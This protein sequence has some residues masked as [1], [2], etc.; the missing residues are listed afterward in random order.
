MPQHRFALGIL[1]VKRWGGAH[2]IR[3]Q[4]IV[5]VNR[6]V[7]SV[8]WILLG[9]KRGRKKKGKDLLQKEHR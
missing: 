7:A 8:Q 3:M 9:A 2:D 1:L 4:E 6:A 5:M